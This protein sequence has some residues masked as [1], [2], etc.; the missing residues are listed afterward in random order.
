MDPM[1]PLPHTSEFLYAR[2]QAVSHFS[3][4][5]SGTYTP[6]PTLLVSP[7]VAHDRRRDMVSPARP[8]TGALDRGRARRAGCG[9]RHAAGPCPPSSGVRAVGA[10]SR[11]TLVDHVV[12]QFSGNDCSGEPRMVL[13]ACDGSPAGGAVGACRAGAAHRLPL[14]RVSG[15]QSALPGGG[16]WRYSGTATVSPRHRRGADHEFTSKFGWA[17]H[18]PLERYPHRGL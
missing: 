11:P 10:G 14:H 8:I 18:R 15:G 4:G 1:I 16:V 2:T 7:G 3:H 6:G 9:P 13:A 12:S 17:A 5:H